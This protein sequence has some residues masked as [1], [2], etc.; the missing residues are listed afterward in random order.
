MVGAP[1]GRVP[2]NH[3]MGIRA[4]LGTLCRKNRRPRESHQLERHMCRSQDWLGPAAEQ[5]V[6]N[7]LSG[8]A[9]HASKLPMPAA[10]R[11]SAVPVR[12]GTR[13]TRHAQHTPAGSRPVC[14]HRCASGRQHSRLRFRMHRRILQYETALPIVTASTTADNRKGWTKHPHWNL[15]S[16][17]DACLWHQERPGSADILC[18]WR[19]ATH[20]TT[21]RAFCLLS[22]PLSA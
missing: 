4:S 13:A 3:S 20:S 8:A 11:C 2:G 21:N 19:Y 16:A 15:R 10:G 7:A 1:C 22:A 17:Q 12:P 9:A 5:K 14:P 18:S 6:I